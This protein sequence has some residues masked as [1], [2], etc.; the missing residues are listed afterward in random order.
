MIE[1]L[2]DRKESNF[3]LVK[4]ED[5]GQFEQYLDFLVSKRRLSYLSLSVVINAFKYYRE[6]MLGFDTVSFY[7]M[8]KIIKSRQLSTVLNREVVG[9]VVFLILL[10]RSLR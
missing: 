9:Q 3:L 6:N 8:P 7:E 5:K 1:I 4:I 2:K 10:E